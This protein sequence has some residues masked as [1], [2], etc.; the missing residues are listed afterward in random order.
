ADQLQLE[1]TPL[2]WPVGMGLNFRGVFDLYSE[3]FVQFGGGDRLGR[4]AMTK[5]LS[6]EEAAKL[7]DD[8]ELVQAGLARSDRAAYRE[9][10]RTPVLFGSAVKNFGV[11]ELLV[12]LAE[13]APAP[14]PVAAKDRTIEPFDDE[15]SGF[16]FKVQANM[17]P[18]HRDRIAF[19]RLASGRF[20][21]SMK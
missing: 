14:G 6:A 4:S 8:I 5:A 16:V 21:R 9:G 12:S 18:N 15:V 17:D 3:E 2:L 13:N 1:T 20:R 7:D 19:V 10:H 11:R